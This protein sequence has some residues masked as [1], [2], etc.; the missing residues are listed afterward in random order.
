MN[1]V[2]VGLIIGFWGAGLVSVPVFPFIVDC[3]G[4]NKIRASALIC[5]CH[6]LGAI[7]GHIVCTQ[8]AN[9]Y[10]TRIA[11]AAWAAVAFLLAL[12][13]AIFSIARGSGQAKTLHA[14]E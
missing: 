2:F 13:T 12:W 1:V 6:E 14:S 8:L 4:A 10:N 5:A 7:V 11:S 3:A 9:A